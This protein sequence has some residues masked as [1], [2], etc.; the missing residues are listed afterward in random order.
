MGSLCGLGKATSEVIAET[1]LPKY[2]R[3]DGHIRVLVQEEGREPVYRPVPCIP[4]LF[5]PDDRLG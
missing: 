4:D 3:T 5:R 1:P 2:I